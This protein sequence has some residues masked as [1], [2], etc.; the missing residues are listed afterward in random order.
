MTVLCS[1]MICVKICLARR[2]ELLTVRRA[3]FMQVGLVKMSMLMMLRWLRE[4]VA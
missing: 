1:V 4:S 3:L 2:V